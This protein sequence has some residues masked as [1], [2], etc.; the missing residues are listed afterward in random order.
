MRHWWNLTVPLRSSRWELCPS[1]F[2]SMIRPPFCRQSTDFPRFRQGSSSPVYFPSLLSMEFLHFCVP[3]HA[4]P[5]SLLH[6]PTRWQHP[7]SPPLPSTQPLPCGGG[8]L[9]PPRGRHPTPSV[10][11]PTEAAASPSPSSI[12]AM[13]RGKRWREERA[14]IFAQRGVLI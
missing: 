4:A 9:P 12:H 7:S 3:V 14:D 11:A 13:V 1:A 5:P 6:L 2:D 8:T 10:C